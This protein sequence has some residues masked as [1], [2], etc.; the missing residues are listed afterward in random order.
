MRRGTRLR[1]T[2]P[3]LKKVVNIPDVYVRFYRNKGLIGGY[4]EDILTQILNCAGFRKIKKIPLAGV[5]LC[6]V[7]LR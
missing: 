5:Q 7:A 4:D 1:V 3:D 6:M 2:C